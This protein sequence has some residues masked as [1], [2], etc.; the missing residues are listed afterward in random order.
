MAGLVTDF[1]LLLQRMKKP[2][3]RVSRGIFDRGGK[4]LLVKEVGRLKALLEEL[5]AGGA[6]VTADA[7]IQPCQLFANGRVQLLQ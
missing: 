3:G 2:R 1:D 7:G 5:L 4:E 6:K